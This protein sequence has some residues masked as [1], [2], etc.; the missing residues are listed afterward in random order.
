MNRVG[1]GDVGQES[2]RDRYDRVGTDRVGSSRD[3]YDRCSTGME[4]FTGRDRFG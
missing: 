1:T 2:S 3:R 4:C